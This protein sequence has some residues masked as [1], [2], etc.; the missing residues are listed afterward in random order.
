[1]TTPVVEDGDARAERFDNDVLLFIATQIE[2]KI[3]SAS[4]NKPSSPIIF[5]DQ[6]HPVSFFIVTPRES[7]NAPAG[8]LRYP[9]EVKRLRDAFVQVWPDITTIDYVILTSP[10]ND[11]SLKFRNA[12]KA[13]KAAAKWGDQ[14]SDKQCTTARGKILI[15]YQP[16][17]SPGEFAKCRVF[18]EGT[19]V[20]NAEKLTW[21][22]GSWSDGLSQVYRPQGTDAGATPSLE[23]SPEPSPEPS[24]SP[25]PSPE[26]SLTPIPELEEP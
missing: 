3:F 19:E 1:M 18:V 22:A 6:S 4:H 26:P 17:P 8:T 23:H 14:V 11:A 9:L 10:L 21:R 25:D 7:E 24:P 20:S 15:Q 16:A 13:R 5:D 2:E 12:K